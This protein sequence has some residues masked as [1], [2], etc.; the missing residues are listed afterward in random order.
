MAWATK[1]VLP[2]TYT[3]ING[4][5]VY[6]PATNKIVLFGGNTGSNTSAIRVYDIDTN[7]WSTASGTLPSAM[8]SVRAQYIANLNIVAI[9]PINSTTWYTCS[10]LVNFSSWTSKTG[11]ISTDSP[12]NATSDDDYMYLVYSASTNAVIVRWEPVSNVRTVLHTATP[13]LANFGVAHYNGFIYIMGGVNWDT[14]EKDLVYKYEIATNTFTPLGGILP[15]DLDST[16][17]IELNGKLYV[18]GGA[19]GSDNTVASCYSLDPTDDSVTVEDSLPT[20]RRL[21][22]L[23]STDSSLYYLGGGTADRNNT[24]YELEIGGGEEPPPDPGDGGSSGD[25]AVA[26]KRPGFIPIF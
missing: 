7:T 14:S 10:D 6:L 23:V 22:A 1:A 13:W 17:G 20:L 3:F 4:S 8:N 26:S 9:M 16:G 19:D 2:A 25:I 11:N 18:A 15:A 21:G 5:A 12:Y 24:V